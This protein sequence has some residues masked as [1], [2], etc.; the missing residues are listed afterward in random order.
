MTNKVKVKFK[1]MDEKVIPPFQANKG[2]AGWD[3]CANEDVSIAPLSV[4][5]INTG[6]M[7]EVPEGYEL[8][9]RGKSG[10]ALKEGFTI[11]QGIGTIDAGYRGEIGVLL[12]SLRP[13]TKTVRKGEMIAQLVL[14]KLPEVEYEEVDELSDSERGKKGFGSTKKPKAKK[15]ETKE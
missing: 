13:F 8:Q 2:D 15:T 3:I 5:K 11:A 9:V 1:K 12:K 7:I 6:L 14:N 4:A 10:L